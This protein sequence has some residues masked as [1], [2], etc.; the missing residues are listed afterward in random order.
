[1]ANHFGYNQQYTDKPGMWSV[2]GYAV[3]TDS[4][5]NLAIQINQLQTTGVI[6]SVQQNSPSA[7]VKSITQT[8]NSSGIYNINLVST[9]IELD[10]CNV[11]TTIPSGLS[12][13]VLMTQLQGNTVGNTGYGPSSS[14]PQSVT[15]KTI[16]PSTGS[17]GT[18]PLGSGIFFHLR[19]KNSSA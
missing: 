12:P 6:T 2:D 9:W 17:A 4:Y 18:L 16:V 15:F 19:L 10:T 1:M 3:V 13:A 11:V 8:A 14:S 7:V 5:A